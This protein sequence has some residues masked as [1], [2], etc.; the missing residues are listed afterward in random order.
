MRAVSLAARSVWQVAIMPAQGCRPAAG[1]CLPPRVG[2][3]A[4]A[5]AAAFLAFPPAPF[6]FTVANSAKLTVG[7][8]MDQLHPSLADAPVLARFA[9]MA[10]RSTRQFAVRR[11]PIA[12]RRQGLQTEADLSN[13]H[14]LLLEQT[15]FS[16]RGNDNHR[17]GANW[18]TPRRLRSANVSWHRGPE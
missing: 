10:P 16:R 11:L 4:A 6:R 3:A 12:G 17:S 18:E 9:A 8:R 5:A 7:H 13:P 14:C 15:A 2:P 1:P